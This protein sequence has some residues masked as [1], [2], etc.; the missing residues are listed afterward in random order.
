MFNIAVSFR[1]LC[2][3]RSKMFVQKYDHAQKTP[4]MCSELDPLLSEVPSARTSA[5]GVPPPD[6]LTLPGGYCPLETPVAATF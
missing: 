3:R 1:E 4:G 2:C 6:P 5:G